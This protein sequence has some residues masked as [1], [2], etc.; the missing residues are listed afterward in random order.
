MSNKSL[1]NEFFKYIFTISAIRM[2]IKNKKNKTNLI[3]HARPGQN[4]P[5]TLNFE[6]MYV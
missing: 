4:K 1:I 6:P 5:D 2:P 3:S